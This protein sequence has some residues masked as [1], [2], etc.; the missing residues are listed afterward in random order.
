MNR[1]IN[2]DIFPNGFSDHH[3]MTVDYN[4]AKVSRPKFYWH[5]NVTLL[6]Q[7]FC[8]FREIWRQRK[9]NLE[10]LTQWWEVGNLRLMF[11]VNDFLIMLLLL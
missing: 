6:L 2:T 11:F 3:M 7:I 1:V 9:N 4:I 5:F 10:N 8:I